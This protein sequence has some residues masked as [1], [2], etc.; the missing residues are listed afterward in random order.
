MET[1]QKI[2]VPVDL[3]E[4]SALAVAHAGMLAATF[5]ADL[6]LFTNVDLAEQAILEANASEDTIDLLSEATE[7]LERLADERAPGVA[8]TVDVR[9]DD[10]PAEGILRAVERSGADMIVIASHGRSG[11][12]RW[13]L[14]SVAE[15]IVRVSPVPVLVIPVRD[16]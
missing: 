13:M 12:S 3:S 15:K 11:M 9:F 8:R 1:P 5:G 16:S 2:F 10:F 14:G 7:A 6:V 4:R